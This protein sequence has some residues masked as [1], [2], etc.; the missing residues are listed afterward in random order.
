MSTIILNALNNEATGY[1]LDGNV[2]AATGSTEEDTTSIDEDSTSNSNTS[3]D[4]EDDENSDSHSSG[5][6]V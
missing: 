3:S 6:R 5:A 4:T 2:G 1:Q